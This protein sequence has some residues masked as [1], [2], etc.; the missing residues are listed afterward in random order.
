MSRVWLFSGQKCKK[1]C[2][3]RVAPPPTFKRNWRPWCVWLGGGLR[4]KIM[5]A[6]TDSPSHDQRIAWFRGGCRTWRIEWLFLTYIVFLIGRLRDTLGGTQSSCTCEG[7]G[8]PQQ[9]RGIIRGPTTHRWLWSVQY[10]LS[11]STSL[12]LHVHPPGRHIHLSYNSVNAHLFRPLIGSAGSALA[13]RPA[14]G[15]AARQ[16]RKCSSTPHRGLREID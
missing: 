3:F 14:T 5:K 11:Q 2:N 9:Y 12:L 1:S 6:F 8:L 4:I 15:T 13:S 10:C 16:H 7:G